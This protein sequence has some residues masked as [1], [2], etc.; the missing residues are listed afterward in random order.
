MGK[1]RKKRDKKLR[2]GLV[3]RQRPPRYRCSCHGWLASVWF[4]CKRW[5]PQISSVYFLATVVAAKFFATCFGHNRVAG[6]PGTKYPLTLT[7]SNMRMPICFH[8]KLW[9]RMDDHL[10]FRHPNP[11]EWRSTACITVERDPT[12]RRSH[13]CT[14]LVHKFWRSISFI[15]SGS[16]CE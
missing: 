16:C 6:W 12:K 13:A 15:S 4:A 5:K 7:K 8:T 2:G 3:A 11:P 10:P 9:P 14:C 1:Q